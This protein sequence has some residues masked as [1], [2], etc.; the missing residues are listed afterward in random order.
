MDTTKQNILMCKKA[1]EIQEQWKVKNGDFFEAFSSVRILNHQTSVYLACY[2]GDD[3]HYS[4]IAKD[5]IH[6]HTW[7]PRQDQLQEMI[8]WLGSI[9]I[10]HIP[11]NML[12]LSYAYQDTRIKVKGTSMEQLW[13][14]FVMKEKFNKV[15]NGK[16]WEVKDDHKTED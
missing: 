10:G 16:D 12:M 2:L 14:A 3:Y 13:L 9:L 5:C 7:L 8:D 1:V 15:W 6:E 4:I 11:N